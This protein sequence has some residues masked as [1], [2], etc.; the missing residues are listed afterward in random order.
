MH[1]Q[2]NLRLYISFLLSSVYYFCLEYNENNGYRFEVLSL[3]LFKDWI[4]D[5][6]TSNDP[7]MQ[8]LNWM[9]RSIYFLCTKGTV[10][11]E[12]EWSLTFRIFLVNMNKTADLFTYTSFFTN[13]TFISNARLKFAENQTNVKQHPET[14][15]SYLKIIQILHSRYHLK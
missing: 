6:Y 4:Q 9:S 13:N 7:W 11:L 10:S 12:K 5:Y 1:E 3:F 15:F 2:I 8:G 14:N